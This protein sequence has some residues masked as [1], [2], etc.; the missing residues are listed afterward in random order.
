[1]RPCAILASEIFFFGIPALSINF[2][3]SGVN[4]RQ[5]GIRT[6]SGVCF[7]QHQR[8]EKRNSKR[9]PLT[10]RKCIA[11]AILDERSNDFH[12]GRG[13]AHALRMYRAFR[14][15]QMNPVLVAP[16]DRE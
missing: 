15:V 8:R 13:K 7:R 3:I 12:A 4:L 1:M 9:R 14:S 2:C 10:Q 5:V 6:P 16:L 11:V